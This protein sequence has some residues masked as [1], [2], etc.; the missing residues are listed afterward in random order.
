MRNALCV[1]LL[2][3]L[4]IPVVA[5]EEPGTKIEIIGYSQMQLASLKGGNLYFLVSIASP[6]RDKYFYVY[7]RATGSVRSKIIFQFHRAYA[8]SQLLQMKLYGYLQWGRYANYPQ[9]HPKQP[10]RGIV[11]IIKRVEFTELD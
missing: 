6:A 3:A 5:Q 1:I 10:V 2:L 7:C 4:A 11:V 8:R 9:I